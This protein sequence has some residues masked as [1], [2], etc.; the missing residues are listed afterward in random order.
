MSTDSLPPPPYPDLSA[1]LLAVTVKVPPRLSSEA[2][3]TSHDRKLM[4]SVV[5]FTNSG[6]PRGHPLHPPAQGGM[7]SGG[8]MIAAGMDGA[9]PYGYGYGAGPMVEQGGGIAGRNNQGVNNGDVRG[10]ISDEPSAASVRLMGLKIK[11]STRPPPPPPPTVTSAP[12]FAS[13]SL[14]STPSDQSKTPGDTF[15]DILTTRPRRRT[16]PTTPSSKPRTKPLSTS[17]RSSTTSIMTTHQFAPDSPSE[18]SEPLP[19]N[20]RTPTPYPPDH[21]H[22]PTDPT[23]PFFDDISGW[24]ADDPTTAITTIDEGVQRMLERLGGGACLVYERFDECGSVEGRGSLKG[25][26]V[27]GGERGRRGAG[28]PVGG[29]GGRGGG[30][31]G[32]GCEWGVEGDA[33]GGG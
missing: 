21:T 32:A 26:G 12:S 30:G 29:G 24:N 22:L 5:S 1:A 15:T 13:S 7:V 2:F 3:K 9:G 19:P 11:P 4:R 20:P 31:E 27:V 6:R 18:T 23:D 25:R 28:G 33:G 17:A 16:T 14:P 10:G 8:E